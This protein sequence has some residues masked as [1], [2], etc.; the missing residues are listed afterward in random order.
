MAYEILTKKP[1][2]LSE[3]VDMITW[4]EACCQ[5]TVKNSGVRKIKDYEGYRSDYDSDG[6][7]LPTKDLRIVNGKKIVTEERINQL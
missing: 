1:R 6:S 5:Q 2:T 7:D 4:H 3:A